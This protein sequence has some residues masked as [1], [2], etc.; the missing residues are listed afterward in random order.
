MTL[1]SCPHPDT[2]VVHTAG[3]CSLCR[4]G[5]D[6]RDAETALRDSA[7]VAVCT[8][9]VEALCISTRADDHEKK[10]IGQRL[11]LELEHATRERGES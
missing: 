9:A 6:L 7:L 3:E 5:R 2:I 10:A 8:E 11:A 1:Q 4:L